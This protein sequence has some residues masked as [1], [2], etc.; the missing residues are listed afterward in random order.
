MKILILG[1]SS[2]GLYSFRRELLERFIKENFKV[3]VCVPVDIHSDDI[4]RIGCRI[5]DNKYLNRRGTN[6]LH[7]LKLIRYYRWLLSKVKPDVVLTYTIKPNVYG[8]L[9]CGQV[10]I[11]YISNVTGL[12]TSIEN[13]GML[14]ILTMGLYRL[15][16]RKAQKIFFQ[17]KGNR[18]FMLSRKVVKKDSIDV[19]PGS[20]VNTKQHCHEPYP[21]SEHQ[22]IFTAIGRIMKDKGTDELLEAARRVKK[23]YPNT[24]FRLIGDFDEG[25]EEKVFRLQEEGVVEYLGFQKDI[26]PFIASSHAIIH[27]SYHEGLSNVLLE[28]AST[29]RPVI[30]T[31]VHGCIE[32]F[33]P[34]VT[35]IAFKAKSTDS[36]VKAIEKFLALD[37]AEREEMGRKGREK[38]I[39]EFD[40]SIVV[41]KYMGEI[42]RILKSESYA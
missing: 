15:G 10:G 7:D 28:A 17:N 30:A 37:L 4:S 26:H 27:A 18:D 1:N 41:D 33:E 6:P 22:I 11:P 2:G 36:L 20:G 13:G 34:D 9:V 32:A 3:Y 12:G 23:A 42:E 5:I 24:I 8:G 25:Y 40:R 14:Q 39:R 35:G 29:G 31:D 19:I 38:M 21:E 16:L